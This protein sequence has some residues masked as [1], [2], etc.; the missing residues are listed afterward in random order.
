MA[1]PVSIDDPRRT[2]IIIAVALGIHVVA[3][4]AMPS[5]IRRMV[6]AIASPDVLVEFE[7]MTPLPEPELVEPEPPEPVDSV[8]REQPADDARESVATH[9]DPAP[10][11]AETPVAETAA[12]AST[13]VLVGA[14]TSAMGVP[15]G[16]VTGSQLR[17]GPASNG[18]DTTAAPAVVE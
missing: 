3:A 6:E 7:T 1:L 9:D 11:P 2:P 10:V 12:P 17:L 18:T 16:Q 15:E 8:E 13:E 5:N 14:G 4:L